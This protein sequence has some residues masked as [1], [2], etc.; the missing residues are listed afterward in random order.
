MQGMKLAPSMID[1]TTLEGADTPHKG[2]AAL[3][4]GAAPATA[5]RPSDGGRHFAMYPS[6]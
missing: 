4:Q 3:L 2:A 1:L 5:A 6:W